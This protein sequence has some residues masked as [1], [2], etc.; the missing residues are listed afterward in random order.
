MGT[1]SFVGALVAIGL[2]VGGWGSGDTA[3]AQTVVLQSGTMGV[4]GAL[5]GVSVSTN[6]FVGWRFSI[7]APL[8][9]DRVGGHLIGYGDGDIFVALVAL[10]SINDFPVGPP[11]T[12][13]EI[14][15]T[16]TFAPPGVSDDVRTPLAARLAP[17]SYAI[18]FGTGL[19][20]AVGNGAVVN[21]NGQEDIPPTTISSYI[22]WGVVDPP[23]WRTNLN[24]RMHFVVEGHVPYAADFND[25]DRVD[26]EDLSLWQGGFGGDDPAHALGNADGDG[27]VDGADFLVWQ[28]QTGA[29][30][31]SA[32]IGAAAPE[33]VGLELAAWLSV[34]ALV[35]RRR[36][37]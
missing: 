35:R 6:Q 18:V 26:G 17:G 3:V 37:P 22:F 31:L 12:S 23:V 15:A 32:T 5:G 1:R 11:F 9:V 13:Q 2:A 29:G 25:D 36:R 33:P 14:M 28:Q 24:S 4:P 19:F 30:P 34:T 27:D 8:A 21:F 16:T 10:S 20:G 7:A